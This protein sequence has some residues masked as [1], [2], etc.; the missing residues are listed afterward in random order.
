M[1]LILSTMTIIYFFL[2]VYCNLDMTFVPFK[3]IVKLPLTSEEE[4]FANAEYISKV[5]GLGRK[6]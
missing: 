5:K 4:V 1:F 6:M 3:S 2:T